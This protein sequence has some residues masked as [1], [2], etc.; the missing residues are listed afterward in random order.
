MDE[1]TARPGLAGPGASHEVPYSTSYFEQSLR[2]CVEAGRLI[3]RQVLENHQVGSLLDIGCGIGTWLRAAG[4]LGIKDLTGLDGQ[5]IDLNSVLFDP[6]V[7]VATDLSKPFRL[8]RR[9]DLAVCSEVAE[10]FP[11]ERAPG[12]VRDIA[13][14]SDVIVFSAALPF[15][16]GD[17]HFN[18][19]WPEYW[20][21]LFRQ[22]GFVCFDP[23]RD[24]IWNDA[25]AESWYAQNALLYVKEGHHL[26]TK[27]DRYRADRRSLSRVH[28]KIFL[29]NVTRS[30]PLASAV[31]QSEIKDWQ[32]IVEAYISGATEIPSLT[33]I[34]SALG[35]DVARFPISRMRYS[36][37][38]E[39]DRQNNEERESLRKKA[40]LLDNRAKATEA[41]RIKQIEWLRHERDNLQNALAG[42]SAELEWLQQRLSALVDSSSWQIT[43]PLRALLRQTPGLARFLRITLKLA[44]W[45]V[46]L[47]LPRKLAEGQLQPIDPRAP[48]LEAQVDNLESLGAFNGGWYGPD[49]LSIGDRFSPVYIPSGPLHQFANERHQAQTRS[50]IEKY[51]VG[52]PSD[53]KLPHFIR[54]GPMKMFRAAIDN[55]LPRSDV[56]QSADRTTYSVVTTYFEHREFFR[57]CAIS[58]AALIDQDFRGSG[59][60]RIEWIVVNDDPNI[61]EPGLRELLP[62]SIRHTVRIISELKNGKNKGVVVPL[63]E[64][65]RAASNEWLLFLDCDDRI[66]ANATIVLDHYIRKFRSCRYI[67][68]AMIDIDEHDQYIRGRRQQHRPSDMIEVGT[69]AGHLKAIRRDLFDEIGE[70]NVHYPGSQDF[71]LALRT[72]LREPILIIPDYLYFYRWHTRSQSV[73]KIEQ[74]NRTLDIIRKTYFH[75]LVDQQWPQPPRVRHSP[76][77]LKRGICLVRTQGRRLSLLAEA[78]QSIADQA[79]P[80]VPCVIVHGDEKRYELV[81]SWAAGLKQETILLNASEPAHR[82]GYPLNVGLDYLRAHADEFDFMCILDDDD[83]FYPT[84]GER[85]TSALELSGCD[86]AYGLGSQ[87]TPWQPPQRSHLPM[88]TP[89]LAVANFIPINSYIVRTDLIVSSEIRLRQDMDYLEDWDF[90]LSLLEAGARF[91]FVPETVSEFRIIGDGNVAQR[92]DPRHFEE[93]QKALLAR[94]ELVASKL[95]IGSFH[96]GLLEFDFDQ[97]PP[98]A[99]WE[100][101]ML[102]DANRTYAKFSSSASALD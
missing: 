7:F 68:S 69:I 86:L 3:L 74:Q 76:K 43:R 98:L 17:D 95:G 18:E 1:R 63:N 77:G 51:Y 30:R 92:K 14:T 48:S 58:V 52:A 32:M 66:A 28:P 47:Q 56:P 45:T 19:Q 10:H 46:S 6:A 36:D 16:G 100:T 42:K 97:R 50:I 22:N 8:P 79:L 101:G 93:C 25:V 87:R 13:A 99:P 23:F 15:Q 82:R 54:F 38:F 81:A 40:T 67:S 2:G 20:A 80:I 35:G 11:H 44:W 41:I 65:L 9:F 102:I 78:I 91:K 39:A 57:L 71:E 37:A 5:Y 4:E 21:I 89:C 94:G 53:I 60:K 84:F 83:I 90:L 85:L 33:T 27:L 34:M 31:L 12:L 61:D 49:Q 96:R 72:S 59:A 24:Q 29:T 26:E 55:Q 70:F 62:A 73:S 64:G 88:P 75:R